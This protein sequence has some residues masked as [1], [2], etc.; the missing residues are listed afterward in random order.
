MK[1]NLLIWIVL[2]TLTVAHNMTNAQVPDYKWAKSAKGKGD[3]RGNKITTDPDG[4][5]IVTGRF[6]SKE[7]MFDSIKL[8]N[9]DQDSSTSDVFIVKYNP[10]SKVLWA[11]SYGGYGD[12]FG[13][14]LCN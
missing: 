11:R 10:D 13:H 6:R 3:D 9:S 5:I 4:N 2:F 1:T 14:L 8:I 12:D 7:I